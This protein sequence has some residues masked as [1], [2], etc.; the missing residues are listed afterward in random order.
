MK[1]RFI[2]S[3]ICSFCCFTLI[4]PQAI[5][6]GDQPGQAVIYKAS[7]NQVILENNILKFTLINNVERIG[8]NSFEDKITHEQLNFKAFPIF[9][10]VLRDGNILSSNDFTILNSCILPDNTEETKPAATTGNLPGK[11]YGADLANQKYNLKIH[12]EVILKNDANYI[13][14]FFTLAAKDTVKISKIGLVKIPG[15]INARVEGTVD[16]SPLVHRNMFFAVEHP[17]SQI[18]RSPSWSTVFLS[19]TAPLTPAQSLTVSAVWGVTPVNQLRRGFLYYVERERARPYH[20]MLHYNSWYDL[21]WEDRILNDSLCLDRIHAYRD[22]LIVKRNV[23]MNAFLFDDGWDDYRT[24]WQ[25]HSQFPQ[26]FTNLRKA[27]EAVG[28]GIGVWMSPWGGYDIRKP[29]RLEY[30]AKQNPPFETNENG[31]TLTGPVYYNYFRNV[32]YDFIKK[33]GVSIFKLDGVG[34]GNEA[35]GANL[36]Y[37]EDI[38]AFLRFT[39]ELRKIKP[40]IYLSLTIGTWPSVY[41]LKY[42]DATWRSGDDTGIGGKGSRRQRWMNYRD[43]VT[44]TNVVKRAPLFPLN[45]IMYHGICIGNVG[46]PGTL[47]MDDKVIADEIWSFFGS[48]TSLQEMYI[49]PHKLNTANWDCLAN[50]IN[51]AKENENVLVDAH[52]V[53]GDPGKGQVYGIAAW[54]PEKAVLTLRNPSDERKIFNVKVMDVFE[55]PDYVKSDFIFYDARTAKT[56]NKKLPLAQGRSF[57]ITLEPFEVKVFDAMPVK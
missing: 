1:T 40:D 57:Q 16:G 27:A 46:I 6:P 3:I 47:E 13:L 11:I 17:M 48:G 39:G 56:D 9:E 44:Y 36:A 30:G 33:Y 24:V 26:G 7:D 5:Y 19:R 21:S 22:S 8:L 54:S 10:L 50:A 23:K 37:Q 12:W 32:A 45:S 52:W 4:K 49:N 34:E 53:G 2:L 31:F 38:E 14:Q 41:F 42:G 43:S 25:F 29:Q 55:L 51:W 20:Q 28:A 15:I 18:D 35:S